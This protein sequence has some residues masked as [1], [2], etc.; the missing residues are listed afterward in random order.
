MPLSSKLFLIGFVALML[1]IGFFIL[2][3]ALSKRSHTIDGAFVSLFETGTTGQSG[4]HESRRFTFD[5]GD[6]ELVTIS[7]NLI[8]YAKAI[9]YKAGA[10]AKIYYRKG[11]FTKRRIYDRFEFYEDPIDEFDGDWS[12]RLTH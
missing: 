12:D 2:D 11:Y 6:G 9:K 10:E 3:D 4:I 1:A 7:S 8:P 5:I